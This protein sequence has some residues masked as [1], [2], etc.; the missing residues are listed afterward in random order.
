MKIYIVTFVVAFSVVTTNL[1]PEP[2]QR[3]YKFSRFSNFA[4]LFLGQNLYQYYIFLKICQSVIIL[5]NLVA[6]LLL[7]KIEGAV[8]LKQATLLMVCKVLQVVHRLHRLLHPLT[9]NAPP[10][11][12]NPGIT[13]HWLAHFPDEPKGKRQKGYAQCHLREQPL[14]VSA[15]KEINAEEQLEPEKYMRQVEGHTAHEYLGNGQ[16]VPAQALQSLLHLHYRPVKLEHAQQDELPYT[17][18]YAHHG[19][20]A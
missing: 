4:N 8:F 6:I 16:A 2:R 3:N 12:G 17:A 14:R 15:G 5:Y 11:P 10:Q 13:G 7:L 20:E 19:K 18:A 9:G 1:C